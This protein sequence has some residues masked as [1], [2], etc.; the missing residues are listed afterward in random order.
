MMVSLRYRTQTRFVVL[1]PATQ[2]A[3]E[4]FRNV[5]TDQFRNVQLFS[6]MQRFRGMVYS[7]DGAV[8]KS[9]LTLDGRHKLPVDERS[10]H[11]LSLDRS[12]RVLGC[13]RYV[14]ERG[15]S[16]FDD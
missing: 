3:P 1:P 15:A 2:Q 7:R 9:D 4:V 14:D 10:W 13:L 5:E 8:Q 6:E 12:D 16:R 11:V